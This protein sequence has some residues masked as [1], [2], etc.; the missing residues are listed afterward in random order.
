MKR[1]KKLTRRARPSLPEAATT[2][3]T[4]AAGASV[5][6]AAV[7]ASPLMILIAGLP[8][9]LKYAY[10]G[11][12]AVVSERNQAR[13][14]ASG[15]EAL[16]TSEEGLTQA[17]R[18]AGINALPLTLEVFDAVART[19]NEQK[20]DALARVWAHGLRDDANL[21]QDVMMVRCLAQLE[22][23]HIQ[24]LKRFDDVKVY[25]EISVHQGLDH[26]KPMVSAIL[27]TL[28]QVGMLN[29]QAQQQAFEGRYYQIDEWGLLALK[30]LGDRA[31]SE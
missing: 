28:V 11:I 29:D 19:L 12:Q 16:G 30:Y 4:S 20:I 21:V 31:N 14:I 23:P 13:L 6:V 1:T 2:A 10:Q 24:V 17:V 15:A 9:G 18:D 3:V 26:L 5:A 7:G 25:S 22:A 27:N 8:A